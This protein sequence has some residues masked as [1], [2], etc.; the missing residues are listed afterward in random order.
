M[1][2]TEMPRGWE[3]GRPADLR[4]LPLDYWI[5][6]FRKKETYKK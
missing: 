4:L 1:A 3:A 6:H 5:I 2:A